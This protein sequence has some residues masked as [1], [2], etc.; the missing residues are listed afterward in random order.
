MTNKVLFSSICNG[1]IYSNYAL[2]C[3]RSFKDLISEPVTWELCVSEEWED[4]L[5][6]KL[7]H[8][9]NGNLNLIYTRLGSVE[10][11]VDVNK[12]ITLGWTPYKSADYFMW[13]IKHLD[14]LKA[15]GKYDT[16]ITIDLDAIFIRN[17][18][19]I[20]NKFIESGLTYGGTREA[21]D[22]VVSWKQIHDKVLKY[23][24][25]FPLKTY[26]NLGFGLLNLNRLP[27]NMW[28]LYKQMSKDKEDWFNT[29]DQSFF[30]Y[31]I[32]DSEKCVLDDAQIVAHCLWKKEFRVN[33]N[34]CLIHFSP[35]SA[36]MFNQLN[37]THLGPYH[38]LKLKYY[39]IF[40]NLIEKESSYIPDSYI[41]N[42]KANLR[43]VQSA[44]RL[45]S[46]LKEMFKFYK[47]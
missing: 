22:P 11:E 5:R 18:M 42:A 29:Q 21:F 32:D 16:V 3:L 36:D 38:L 6:N 12:Y 1:E 41:K 20:V 45:Q 8:L 35:C 13:R 46:F 15:E 40:V 39:P 4:R 14:D 17:P 31:I 37:T 24:E 47:I 9:N 26:F 27:T 10:D 28:E 7:E 33:R 2:V 23:E 34:P 25:G 44:L 19:I 43:F 30:S